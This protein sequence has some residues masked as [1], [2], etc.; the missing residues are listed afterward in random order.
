MNII[1]SLK[2]LSFTDFAIREIIELDQKD[3][4]RPW[5]YE[6][7]QNINWNYHILYGWFIDADLVGFILIGHVTGDNASHLL[8]ICLKSGLRGSGTSHLMWETFLNCLK[9]LGIK[10]I[11]LEVEADNS[12]AV[13]FYTKVQFKQIRVVHSFYSDGKDGIMM[14][15]TL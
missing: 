10:S 11:F 9:S 8:K 5:S 12:R 13:G 14:L 4:P 15:L 2:R 1:G 3:F 7:W 6:D